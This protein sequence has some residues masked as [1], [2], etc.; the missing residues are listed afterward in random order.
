MVVNNMSDFKSAYFQ[1]MTNFPFLND[2]SLPATVPAVVE[3]F[4]QMWSEACDDRIPDASAF[5][6]ATLGERF[7]FLAR[8]GRRNPEQGDGD[9]ELVWCDCA[10]MQ[11]WPFAMPVVGRP[12]A[13]SLP[14]HSVKRVY[15]ALREV[16]ET[17][18]PSYFEITTWHNDG[19]E[20]SMGRLTAPVRAAG[21]TEL[22]VLWVPLGNSAEA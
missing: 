17:C 21:R 2:F 22:L 13:D 15:A 19:S 1:T 6:L 12:V 14:A 16:I 8:I 5:D 10:G 18:T 20:L 11:D 9:G 4:V 7:R 3:S